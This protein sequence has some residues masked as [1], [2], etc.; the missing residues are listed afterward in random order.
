M[1]SFSKALFASFGFILCLLLVSC[2]G[3][4]KPPADFS[5]S[6]TPG[7]LTLVP[8]GPS[9][10]ISVNA[11][12]TNG[13]NGMVAV[14]ISGLPSGISAQPSTLSLTP[15]T[16]QT[17]TLSAATSAAAGSATLT[18]TGTSGMLSHT[19]SVMATVAPPPDFMLTVAPAALNLTAGATTGTSVNVTVNPLNSFSG[20]VAVAITGLPSGVTANPST[21][22]L[23]PGMPQSTTLLAAVTTAGGTSNISFTGTAGSLSHSSPVALT[24]QAA[25]M[26]Q[27]PDVTTFHYD[28]ARTGLNSQETILTQANVNSTSF[29]KLGLFTMD[30]KVDAQPLYLANVDINN[31]FHNVLYAASEHGTLYAFDADT[32]TQLWTKSTLGAG[33]IP[34]DTHNCSQISPEIGISATPVIDRKQGPNGTIFVVGTSKDASGGYHHRLHALDLTT[35]A[36]IGTPTEVTAT[37]PGTGDNSQNGNVVFDPAQYAER[38]A[39]LLLNGTIYTGWTSHCDAGLY[40]TWLMTYDETTLA[41][42]QVLNLTPN[43]HDGLH[44]DERRRSG[45]R[46]QQ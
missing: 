36:E 30:G 28:L 32:G 13:F 7:T 22:M 43:G 1:A 15:G 42:K 45:R 2:S 27:A 31:Q 34:S 29:G 21:L 5:L 41:Q 33:E 14:A 39:L 4:S 17:V 16:A 26:T 35:G 44:L 8:G 24:V 38:A 9:Q 23:M 20:Q 3:G 6:T 11:T 46:F 40:N 19:S 10:P 12:P 25:A 37:F 18:L